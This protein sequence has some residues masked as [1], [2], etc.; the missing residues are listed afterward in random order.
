[1]V[2]E[3]DEGFRIT[4]LPVTMAAA[5]MP[6]MMAKGKFQGENDSADSERDVEQLVALAGILNG[7]RSGGQSQRLAGVELEKVDGLADIGV[8]FG[9]VFANFIGE[10]GHEF[11]LALTDDSGSAKEQRDALIG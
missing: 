1:M 11:E 10:P 5:V 9:P 6:A 3:S 8:G 2:G 7:S 4:V